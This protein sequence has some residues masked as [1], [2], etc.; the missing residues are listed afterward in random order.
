MNAPLRTP[1][2]IGDRQFLAQLKTATRRQLYMQLAV[3]KRLGEAAEWKR[4]ATERA[5]AN[6]EG[7]QL[8]HEFGWA[9]RDEWWLE[10]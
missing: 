6:R 9:T 7:L 5:I 10:P 1:F 2:S 8:P 4:A 3:F